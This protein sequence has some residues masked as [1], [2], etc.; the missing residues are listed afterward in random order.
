MHALRRVRARRRSLGAYYVPRHNS[1]TLILIASRVAD[2]RYHSVVPRSHWQA[3][4]RA[5][6]CPPRAGLRRGKGAVA[7]R[8]GREGPAIHSR[9]HQGGPSRPRTVLERDA[10]QFHGGLRVQRHVYPQGLGFDLELLHPPSQRRPLCRSVRFSVFYCPFAAYL[11]TLCRYTF[12]PDRYLGDD[13]S[14]AESAH[15]SN[16]MERDHWSFGAG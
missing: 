12:N 1:E 3:P 15:I 5:G 13:L 9:H 8:R 2:F 10:A 4:G 7:Q 16:A 14:S 6:S 11:T